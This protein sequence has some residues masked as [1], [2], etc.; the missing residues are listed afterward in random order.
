MFELTCIYTCLCGRNVAHL[1]ST[2]NT[3]WEWKCKR[4]VIP[5]HVSIYMSVGLYAYKHILR[6]WV[7]QDA[8][9]LDVG[10]TWSWHSK[11]MIFFAHSQDAYSTG[12]H[13]PIVWL[14][15]REFGRQEDRPILF[16]SFF[17]SNISLLEQ[18]NVFYFL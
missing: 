3:M 11:K 6:C 12:G 7:S 14:L 5:M 10:I 4:S 15:S 18:L 17:F 16:F 2:F 13:A 8:F 1:D 9:N